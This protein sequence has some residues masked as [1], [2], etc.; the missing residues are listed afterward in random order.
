[1]AAKPK[2]TKR[3]REL[4]DKGRAE[5]KRLFLHDEMN[6]AQIAARLRVAAAY[7]MRLSNDEGWLD[8][9]TRLCCCREYLDAHEKASK[10][11]ADCKVKIEV[12]H[13]RT[14]V[15]RARAQHAV[16]RGL[17]EE[18]ASAVTPKQIHELARVLGPASADIT[19]GRLSVGLTT[20]KVDTES[21][22]AKKLR[23]DFFGALHA[24]LAECNPSPVPPGD[25]GGV[26]PGSQLAP[27]S[28]AAQGDA[29]QAPQPPDRSR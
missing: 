17:A 11:L 27:E 16:A 20:E 15:H 6:E 12:T 14:A 24:R 18:A 8:E 2:T 4:D 29:R 28:V 7:V 10:D 9:V 23:S 19:S 25:A 13:A 26:V 5:A 22:D 21:D 3:A 1:M